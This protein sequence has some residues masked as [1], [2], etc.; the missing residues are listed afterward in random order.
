MA[1][2]ERSLVDAVGDEAV[3]RGEGVGA[4]VGGGVELVVR[5]AAEAG[6][7]GVGRSGFL[8]EQGIADVEGEAGGEAAF[9]FGLE[10]VAAAVTEILERR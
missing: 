5:C 9:H 1:A 2:T 10:G 3:G 6:V 7:A 8:I 4:V